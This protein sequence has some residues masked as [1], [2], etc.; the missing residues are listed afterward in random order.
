M[1][2]IQQ[3]RVRKSSCKRCKSQ[4]SRAMGECSSGTH[5]ARRT[6]SPGILTVPFQS[7]GGRGWGSEKFQIGVET[8][9]ADILEKDRSRVQTEKEK[10]RKH[11]SKVVKPR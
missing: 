10:R 3:L 9:G 6:S 4:A 2:G 11:S 5:D 1:K 8:Q 7:R